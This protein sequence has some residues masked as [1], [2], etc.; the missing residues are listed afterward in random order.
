[1]SYGAI[2]CR[3]RRA[4]SQRRHV[5]L[6]AKQICQRTASEVLYQ[7]FKSFANTQ[8]IFTMNEKVAASTIGVG[9]TYWLPR[10]PTRPEYGVC[11][12]FAPFSFGTPARRPSLHV[13]HIHIWPQNLKPIPCAPALR[14]RARPRPHPS[15][16][17]RALARDEK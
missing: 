5:L 14:W 1:M 4:C 10:P 3:S 2:R 13:S 17:L 9:F 11:V 8:M 12:G 16:A 6:G 15:P 7:H